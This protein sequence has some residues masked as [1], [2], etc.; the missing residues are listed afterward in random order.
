MLSLEKLIEIVLGIVITAIITSVFLYCKKK[1]KK[2]IK[3]VAPEIFQEKNEKISFDEKDVVI[4]ND[5]YKGK[6]LIEGGYE[7]EPE[8]ED[9]GIIEIN[10]EFSLKANGY[11]ED[12]KKLNIPNDPHA[13]IV[14]KYDSTI[15][16]VTIEIKKTAYSNLKSWRESCDRKEW[17]K[18]LSA[19]SLIIDPVQEKIVLHFRSHNSATFPNHLHT[20]GGAYWPSWE[21]RD[22]DRGSIRNTAIR[23]AFEEIN[24]PIIIKKN[25]PLCLLYEVETNFLQF[26]YLGCAVHESEYIKNNAEGRVKLVGFNELEKTFKGSL[27]IVPTCEVAILLWLSIGAPGIA[28]DSDFS[29]KSARRLFQ[30]LISYKKS[31][32][33]QLEEIVAV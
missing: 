9:L 13:I 14:N 28:D 17:P 16:P 1:I 22:G 27:K 8:I 26:V 11:A 15:S 18:I 2:K 19:S 25:T 3:F 29:G 4:I 6:V 32:L 10:K 30:E 20:I 5:I 21:G 23:E 7:F 12:F 31:K 33:K 24:A